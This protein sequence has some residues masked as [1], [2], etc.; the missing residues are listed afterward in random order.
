MNESIISVRYSKALFESALEKKI[1]DKVNN[2]MIFIQEMCKAPETREFL[3]NPVIPP[4]KKKEILHKLLEG[5][6]ENI[7]LS[8]IDLIVKNG[9]EHFLPGIARVFIHETM[10]YKGITEAVLTTAVPVDPK[11][12]Q[13]I[14]EL[15]SGVFSTKIE[16]KEVI[17]PDV[18]GGFIL[19][20]DDNFID[21]SVKNKLRK[22]RKELLGNIAATR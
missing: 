7:T 12:K 8:L 15:I 13:Q 21:A 10:K 16:L 19:K 14:S 1:I 3:A 11:V 9:R 2:D 17:S 6:V 18:I 22:I 20:V 5:N 4:S